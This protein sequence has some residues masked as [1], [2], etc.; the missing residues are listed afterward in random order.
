M[1]LIK[2]PIH[3]ATVI[4][5]LCISISGWNDL[6]AQEPQ[7]RVA[8][9]IDDLPY[10][11]LTYNDI[12]EWEKITA[13]LLAKISAE[14]ISV[15]G[16]VNEGKLYKDD[17]LDSARV[18]LLRLWLNAGIELGNHTLTHIDLHHNSLE[19]FKENAIE[20]EKVTKAL[21]AEKGWQLR[22]FRHPYL[23]TGRDLQT[24]QELE[25]F[26][27]E[28]GYTIAP[29][30]I[31]NSEWIFARAYDNAFRDQ[32]TL[33]LK[34]VGE[35]YLSYMEDKIAYYERQSNALFGYELKQVLLLHINRLNADYFDKL[36][37]MM[38]KR[39]YQF[40]TLKEALEDPAY[41]SEDTFIGGGGISW[42]D[43]WAL[44]QGKQGEF[45]RGEP[46]T[47]EFILELAGVDS[48]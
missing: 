9:T 22:Y 19:E 16:F 40:I 36:V 15:I 33:K 43:R 38:K 48:E 18:D 24:K 30:T 3:S 31:D 6:P 42:L 28:R 4:I 10:N 32:D 26:L 7:R 12:D 23:H 47:P 39:E 21:L 20:G 35:E 34:E 46:R 41:L 29:V 25:D 5:F 11:T 13:R 2:Q 17:V 27:K 14:N 45:F 37:E 8:V 44:T 1:G